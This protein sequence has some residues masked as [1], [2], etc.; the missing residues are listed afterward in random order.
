MN[1]SR[2]GGQQCGFVDEAIDGARESDLSGTRSA[3]VDVEVLCIIPFVNGC[4]VLWVDD[5]GEYRFNVGEGRQV[6]N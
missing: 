2:T 1:G 4:R 5:E 3:Q 6:T